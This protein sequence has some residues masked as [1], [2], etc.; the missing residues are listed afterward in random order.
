[1][2]WKTQHFTLYTGYSIENDL[3]YQIALYLHPLPRRQIESLGRGEMLHWAKPAFK[4]W[5]SLSWNW[6]PTL[7]W[8]D[9]EY[10]IPI[11]RDE[12][13]IPA[14]LWTGRKRSLAKIS[15]PTDFSFQPV[16]PE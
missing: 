4:A 11:K 5:I 16:Q 13:H 2:I 14:S 12:S 3:D 1:M 9:H 15:W 10:R 6:L 8:V 7:S